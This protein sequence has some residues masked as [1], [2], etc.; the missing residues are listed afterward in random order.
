MSLLEC[1]FCKNPD[2]FNADFSDL[3]ET[4]DRVSA[5]GSF[6]KRIENREYP[7]WPIPVIRRDLDGLHSKV[8]IGVDHFGPRWQ[9][10]TVNIL[11]CDFDVRPQMPPVPLFGIT[12]THG[13][14]DSYILWNACTITHDDFHFVVNV[15]WWPSHDRL[16]TVEGFDFDNTKARDALNVALS[17]FA[18]GRGKPS[19]YFP[20]NK[21]F[22]ESLK[23]AVIRRYDAGIPPK[24]I[25]A[26]DIGR[27]LRRAKQK[28]RRDSD[29]RQS[30]CG[31]GN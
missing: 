7:A 8:L 15:H 25:L 29:S 19:E 12:T 3:S 11:G 18:R 22:F 31:L 21:Q 27:R 6:W 23:A 30:P 1:P 24:R 28:S 14:K 5:R 4:A 10:L 20:S 16:F 17:L 26:I 13:F 9:A 2:L